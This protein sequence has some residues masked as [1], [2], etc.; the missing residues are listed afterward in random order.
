MVR[1][2]RDE[3]HS[4][5]RVAHLRDPRVDLTAGKLAAFAGLGALGHLDL[6]LACVD[7]V[8][9]RHP[10]AG[11]GHLLDRAVL[12]VAVGLE[13]V[14]G[15]VL[16]AFAGV[17]LAA[18][19]VH[20][21]GQR[22]V[23]LLADRAV[24]HCS[25]LEAA[26]DGL[27]RL[28][29][30]EGHGGPKRLQ[31][32]EPAQGRAPLLLVVDESAELLEEAEVVR[33]ASVLQ[34]VDRLR[35]E[36]VVLA[37]VPPLVLAPGI[38]LVGRDP[39]RSKGRPVPRR[40]LAGHDPDP[41]AGDARR[42]PGEVLV[43]QVLVEADGLEDLGPAVAL[44]GGD[45]HLGDHLHHPLVQGLDVVLDRVLFVDSGQETL[46]HEVAQGLEGQVGVHGSRAVADEEGEVVHLARLAALEHEAHARARAL[47]DQVVVDAGHRQEGGDG[48]VLGVHPAVREHDDVGAG[49]HCRARTA[50]DVVHGPF[51]PRPSRLGREQDGN[52]RGLEGPGPRAAL[53]RAQVAQL[54]ELLVGEDGSPELDLVGRERG[55]IEQVLLGAHRGVGRH[56]QLFA[57]A[58]DGRVR[59]L[60]E[61][62]LEVVVEE[63][64]PL[65]EDG[66]GRVVAHRSHR[67]DAF[68]AHGQHELLN[69]LAAVAERELSLEHRLVVGLARGRRLRHLLEGDE[70]VAQP[71][72]VR[73]ARW[74][75]AA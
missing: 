74:P 23:R 27:D 3:A 51:E 30:F 53:G 46:A 1:R 26:H 45:P 10:E 54:L 75:C 31:L 40:R 12:R 19:P 61:E 38:E 42:S 9:A 21:H 63:L 18:D 62:L 17:A 37:V 24:R 49:G 7:E 2:G 5:C 33:A 59:D 68:L 60:G 64:G 44:D 56:D 15:R 43:D 11:R 4:G 41:D 55:R 67:L 36:E 48:R 69:V 14:T 52:G 29:L 6:Q 57:D 16:A 34:L 66:Q 70:V 47:A 50:A 71:L 58:V 8:V 65:G 22:L 20:G 13:E 32:H 28:D 39:A 72:A 73:A 35:V 25:G